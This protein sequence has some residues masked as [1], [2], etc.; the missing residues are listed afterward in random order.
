MTVKDASQTFCVDPM[1]CR[2]WDKHDR[3][4]EL[5]NEETCREQIASVIAH[6]QVVPALGRRVHGDPDFD[7]ELI[8]GSR[9]LFVARHLNVPLLLEVRQLS[10]RQAAVYMDIENRQRKDIS[11]YER[12]LSYERWLR[13]GVFS[14]QEELA[15]TCKISPAQ[16]SR[17]LKLARIPSVI[18][19][20]FDCPTNVCETWAEHL[21]TM[22]SDPQ[23]QQVLSARARAIAKEGEKLPASA[24]YQRLIE[25]TGA[26]R[27]RT[28]SRDARGTEVIR[29]D[30][31]AALLRVKQQRETV[32]F[33]IPTARMTNERLVRVKRALAS[34]LQDH[35][36]SGLHSSAHL[37]HRR[38][39]AEELG[40]RRPGAPT[41][42][43]VA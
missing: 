28:P 30:E 15:R 7:Y 10:D 18:L 39:S 41:G 4:E 26:F 13:S 22:W 20:A 43:N 8:Y 29:T 19:S 12:G 42:A 27:R 14:S 2:M 6:G 40:R 9:R 37:R 25:G 36:I 32:A 5:V 33:V 3:L 21:L 24:V 17:L 31:G 23:R 35:D 38:T 1:R 16:V 11:P 34:I